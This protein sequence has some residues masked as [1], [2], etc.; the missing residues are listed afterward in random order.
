MFMIRLPLPTAVAL[1]L[2]TALLSACGGGTDATIGGT[3]TGLNTGSSLTLQN[4]L[5]DSLTLTANGGFLFGTTLGASAAYSVTVLTQPVGQSCSV[6][7]ASGTTDTLDSSVSNVAVTCV[8]SASV[9]GTVTG[10]PAGTSVTLT[11][12]GVLL[13]IAANGAF[14]FPGVLATG[15]SYNVTVG[16]Q[17]AGHTCTV[18]N[19]SGVIIANTLVAAAVTCI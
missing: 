13:P 7:N 9:M 1:A 17:P 5:S 12:A 14:A 10:L 2:S 18:T 19:G 11:N 16:V 8:T 15:A 6:A 4:N 3:L